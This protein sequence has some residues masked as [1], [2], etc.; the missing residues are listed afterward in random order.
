MLERHRF[1]LARPARA[2]TLNITHP[3]GLLWPVGQDLGDQDPANCSGDGSNQ[4]VRDILM[5][6]QRA[7]VVRSWGDC[8][9]R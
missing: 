9:V 6:E 4:A 2:L 3:V 7:A 8:A 1:V 5:A